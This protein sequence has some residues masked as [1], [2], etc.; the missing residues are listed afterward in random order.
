MRNFDAEIL[1]SAHLIGIPCT[2]VLNL[3]ATIVFGG[4]SAR[5]HRHL[6]VIDF[7]FRDNTVDVVHREGSYS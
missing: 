4:S 5:E 3:I 1:A 6:E 2:G 7:D